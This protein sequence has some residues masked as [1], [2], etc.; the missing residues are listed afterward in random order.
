MAYRRKQQMTAGCPPRAARARFVLYAIA[1]SGLNVV[2][3]SANTQEN[4]PCAQIK[5]V[6]TEAG[7]AQ[8]HAKDGAGLMVDCIRPVMQGVPQRAKA[9]KPL[10]QIDPKIIAACKAKNPNFGQPKPAPSK[11]SAG[12]AD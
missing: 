7:F 9:A 2:C 1:V 11:S 8:G 10:P 6:C 3:G 4:A 5:I 12:N